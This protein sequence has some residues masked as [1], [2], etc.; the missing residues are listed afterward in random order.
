[1]T[2]RDTINVDTLYLTNVQGDNFTVGGNL[3]IYV[4][5]T[6]GVSLASTIVTSSTAV[7]GKFAGN[8]VEFNHYNHGMSADNNVVDIQGIAPDTVPTTL[9]VDLDITDTQI[10]LADTT[11]YSTFEGITTASGYLKVNNE[12]IYYNSIG[13]GVLGIATRG[14]SGTAIQKHFTNDPVYKYEVADVSLVRINAQHDMAAGLSNL[15]DIDTYHIEFNRGGRSSGES[16][17]NFRDEANVGGKNIRASRNVQFNMMQPQFD[18]ITPGRSSSVTGTVR[19]VSGTSAGGAE[20]S[21]IDQG[22]EAVQIND[23]N[24]LSTTRLVCSQ[25][26]ETTRLTALPKNRS[27]TV[28]VSMS[29]DPQDPNLSPAIDTQTAFAIFGRNRLNKPIT[30]YVNDSRSNQLSGDPHSAVYI[31]NRVTLEQPATSLKVFVG[32]YKD[33]SADFRVMYRL[34]KADSSEVEQAYVLFPGYDNMNDTDQDGFGDTV[35]DASK[36]SGRADALVPPSNIDE[37]NEYQF[38]IENLEQFTGYQIKLVMSG[39]NEARAPRFKDLRA[40]ALA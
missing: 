5:D 6:V 33:A 39:T 23:V 21:F 18:I 29:R 19:T 32:A 40:I 10:S 38:S 2:I 16:M 31:T 22:F 14:V 24:E 36:N 9:S 1:M 15:R 25:I 12:I 30:D 13:S 11:S 17:I 20:P 37:F 4:N 27:L 3:Q 8:V 34:F 35:V 28:G 26:N 7:G